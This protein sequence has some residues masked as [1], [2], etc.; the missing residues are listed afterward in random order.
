MARND[1][2]K[3]NAVTMDDGFT[4]PL[5]KL[6]TEVL[7]QTMVPLSPAV[8]ES[9]VETVP[10]FKPSMQKQSSEDTVTSVFENEQAKLRM[11]M[12]WLVGIKGECRGVDYRLH[13]GENLIGRGE[14]MDVRLTDN[15]IDRVGVMSVF[16]DPRSN[17]FFANKGTGNS[18]LAYINDCPVMGVQKLNPYD[19]IQLA[20]EKNGVA[21]DIC[22]LLFVPLCGEQFKWADT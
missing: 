20:W 4:M 16:Y 7:G 18:C 15:R 8:D 5:S 19:H 13:S 1:Y 11:V 9:D 21:E 12:G 10:M 17:C 2:H 6:P 14:N 22:E 3:K